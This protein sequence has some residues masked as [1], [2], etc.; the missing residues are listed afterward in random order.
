MCLARVET[1]V[2][3][4]VLEHEQLGALIVPLLLEHDAVLEH[5]TFERNQTEVVVLFKFAEGLGDESDS[6]LVV[7][8]TAEGFIQYKYNATALHIVL[9][10]EPVDRLFLLLKRSRCLA[11]RLLADIL[12]SLVVNF[13]AFTVNQL[14]DFLESTKSECIG[15]VAIQLD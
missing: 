8:N 3:E 2:V 14:L 12:Q 15:A 9:R 7:E 6:T 5:G 4:L 1:L 10:K 13:L 11:F